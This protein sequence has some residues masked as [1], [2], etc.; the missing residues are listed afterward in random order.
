MIA[1]FVMGLIETTQDTN[2]A[3][4]WLYRLFPGFCLG[5]GLFNVA[6]NSL[7]ETLVGHSGITM[8][9]DLYD[10]DICGKDILYLYVTAPPKR[11]YADCVMCCT[12]GRHWCTA[13][14]D[15]MQIA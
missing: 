4:I 15:F 14:P 12:S 6:T 11:F 10:W 7:I 13:P 8:H 5:N 1:S 3:L 9:I 2:K